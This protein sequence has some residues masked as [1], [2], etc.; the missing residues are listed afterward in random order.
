MLVQ[1]LR[2]N[3][4]MAWLVR[5]VRGDKETGKKESFTYRAGFRH[6]KKIRL[7]R[8][9]RRIPFVDP[10]AE[11]IEEDIESVPRPRYHA[12]S[13]VWSHGE[14]NR[15]ITLNGRPFSISSSEYNILCKSSSY[16]GPRNVWI[17]TI[18]INQQDDVEKASQIKKMRDIYYNARAVQ[19]YLVDHP[20]SWLAVPFLQ[21]ILRAYGGSKSD[22]SAMMTEMLLRRKQDKWLRARIDALLDLLSNEWFE[23]AWV[24]Q[25]FVMAR[26]VVVNYGKHSFDWDQFIILAQMIGDEDIP[27]V[28]Q[29]LM[30]G[31]NGSSARLKSWVQRPVRLEKWRVR[32]L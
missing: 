32:V 29:C 14:K 31:G 8:I 16:F 23:R 6:D 12:I 5:Q 9:K 20:S 11:L 24:I 22:C 1:S 13:P 19:V 18:C 2:T 10:E 25:E 27:E 30:S 21:Q 4:P 3:L 26:E 28:A 7:L 17:D 15:T